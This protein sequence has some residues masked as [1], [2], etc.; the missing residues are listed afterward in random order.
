MD[1]GD[2]NPALL[3]DT[4]LKLRELLDGARSGT[5]QRL[6]AG[7]RPRDMTLD[8]LLLVDCDVEQRL[9]VIDRALGELERGAG[10]AELRALLAPIARREVLPPAAP[11]N[12]LRH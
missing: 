12:A 4:L 7:R 10:E 6:A 11:P 9:S 8:G 3:R 5:W 1:D 2:L